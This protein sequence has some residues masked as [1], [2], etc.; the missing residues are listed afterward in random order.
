MIPLIRGTWSSQIHRGRK[1][2]GGYQGLGG[3]G[4]GELVFNGYGVSVWEDE[5]F[6]RWMVVMFARQCECI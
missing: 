6:W 4:N 1:K 2:S 5:K 3:Q